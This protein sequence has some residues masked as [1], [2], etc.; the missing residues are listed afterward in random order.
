M[1]GLYQQPRTLSANMVISLSSN[2]FCASSMTFLLLQI[3]RHV[4]FL[5][6]ISIRSHFVMSLR[7]SWYRLFRCIS[8]SRFRCNRLFR[9]RSSRTS[10]DATGI[11]SSPFL[12]AVF[13]SSFTTGPGLAEKHRPM[14][15]P[16]IW[17]LTRHSSKACHAFKFLR[18]CTT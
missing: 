14:M 11:V 13:S 9:F 4:E 7:T 1:D 2:V 15:L 8:L 6:L 16:M 17:L 5:Y 18:N 3:W 10:S 12:F